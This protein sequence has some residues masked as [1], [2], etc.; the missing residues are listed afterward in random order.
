[1]DKSLEELVWLSNEVGKD[2]VLAVGTGGNTSSKTNDGTDMY[3][4][5]S[6][7]ALG[8]LREDRGWRKI[9][10]QAVLDLMVDAEL[11]GMSATDREVAMAQRLIA[12][13]RDGLG[14]DPRPSVESTLH[15]VVAKYGVHLHALPSLAYVCAK[16]GEARIKA[17]F[18]GEAEEPLW[19]PYANPGFD[20]GIIVRDHYNAYAAQHGKAPKVLF[21]EKHG[22]MVCSDDAAEALSL[23]QKTVAL[24]QSGLECIPEDIQNS[25]SQAEIDR[26][27]KHILGAYQQLD[28][29]VTDVNFYLTP[30]MALYFGDARVQAL[31]N[32]GPLTPDEI[33][34]VEN[35]ILIAASEL[36]SLSDRL[37]QNLQ[38]HGK[39]PSIV[40]VD[41]VGIFVV[42]AKKFSEVVRDVFASTLYVRYFAAC[43]GGINILTEA[44]ERFVRNWEGEKYRVQRALAPNG[45]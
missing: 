37:Q 6:G 4:K 17:L 3:I 45:N 41:G 40:F 23:T 30:V 26:T 7:A 19:V 32:A 38:A 13:A 25:P 2:D 28:E 9:D 43:M 15:A 34:F 42:G 33:G 1:M 22:M 27:E 10:R 12:T 14:D 35:P 39:L 21:F 20:L 44:Q 5:A 31:I 36:N 16:E 8:E 29:K 24:C 18:S 11:L